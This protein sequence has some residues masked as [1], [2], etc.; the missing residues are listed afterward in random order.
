VVMFS[1]G[2][3]VT[4][5]VLQKLNERLPSLTVNIVEEPVAN[6]PTPAAPPAAPPKKKKQAE[7]FGSTRQPHRWRT[8]RFFGRVGPF[9]LEV[10][11]VP[12]QGRDCE[13]PADCGRLIDDAPL[14]ALRTRYTR[15]R[16]FRLPGVAARSAQFIRRPGAGG[17]RG[18]PASGL[19]GMGGWLFKRLKS[20]GRGSA[21]ATTR[22]APADGEEAEAVAMAAG[23]ESRLWLMKDV[24]ALID[25]RSAKVSA[26]TLVG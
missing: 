23:I 10:L 17:W 3:D 24:V 19:P 16:R 15:G 12:Q 22:A 25:A 7:P 21:L 11:A 8:S 2:F 26:E 1:P 13:N 14:A 4:D 5:T 6:T 18:D 9:S 20:G